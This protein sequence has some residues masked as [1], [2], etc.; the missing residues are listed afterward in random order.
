M[1]NKYLKYF[2]AFVVVLSSVRGVLVY[3]LGI[4]P[5]ITY[6]VTGMLLIGFGMLSLR[7]MWS[8]TGDKTFALLSNAIRINVMLIGFY[9]LMSIVAMSLNDLS[10]F[11]YFIIF[12][13]I[14]TLIK[15]D[16]KLLNGMIYSVAFITV[17]GVVYFYNLGLSG[18]FRAIQD[19]HSILRSEFSYSRI[20]QNL[21]P[22]GYQ[23]SHHD[24]ANILVMSSA[25]FLSKTLLE[26]NL[27]KKYLY[28]VSYFIVLFS[29]LLTGSVANTIVLISISCLTLLIYAR[30]RPWVMLLILFCTMFVFPFIVEALGDY[31][32]FYQK[33]NYDQSNLAG[34]G[35]YNSLDSNSILTS[36]HS[37]LF[38][39]GFVLRVPLVNTEIGFIKILVKVGLVPFIF[40]MSI[41]FAP[42]YYTL[43]F[44]KDSKAKE[45]S[46]RYHY[47]GI[48]MNRFKR[49]RQTYQ[50]R[51]IVSAMPTIAGT[52]TLLHYSSL[53]RITSIGLFCVLLAL[54]FKEYLVLNKTMYY[55]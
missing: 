51:L 42:V 12:P 31:T 40:L 44:I 2:W 33:A 21:L 4:P 29:L 16:T 9:A 38:G 48:P 15:Y 20:D 18:G 14:F 10:I 32:Y 47:A 26:L 54:F 7:A 25:F 3:H 53:F 45:L 1:Q 28:I 5:R 6:I 36:L 41:C 34:G 43:R 49:I 11:Y 24:A 46:F 8:N 50:Y 35:M 19:A 22:A 23:G 13:I 37:I 27:M 39:F 55:D 17:V 52:F 30:K